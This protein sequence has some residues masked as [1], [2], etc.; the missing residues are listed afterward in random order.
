MVL[1]A[2]SWAAELR[3][4]RARL[5]VE[6]ARREGITPA[7]VSQ[8]WPLRKIT[9]DPGQ[10][11]EDENF[12]MKRCLVSVVAVLGLAGYVHFPSTFKY[13][14][15]DQQVDLLRGKLS[16]LRTDPRVL[17]PLGAPVAGIESFDCIDKKTRAWYAVSVDEWRLNST[18]ALRIETDLR[19]A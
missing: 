8:L 4:G 7:R 2:R 9:R 18:W 12:E 16:Q 15:S 10:R 17:V 19:P 3:R 13:P 14:L 11:S 1:K 5:C 6:I